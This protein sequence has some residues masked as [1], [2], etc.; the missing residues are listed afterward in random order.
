MTALK[1]RVSRNPGST[2]RKFPIS[3]L[4]G[5][6]LK[7]EPTNAPRANIVIVTRGSWAGWDAGAIIQGGVKHY[8]PLRGMVEGSII[9]SSLRVIV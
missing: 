3:D 4:L 9:R 7:R 8:I 1:E 5:K 6:S 2:L